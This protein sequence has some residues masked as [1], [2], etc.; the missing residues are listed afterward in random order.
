MDQVGK[1][2]Q[3]VS[4]KAYWSWVSIITGNGPVDMY[5]FYIGVAACGTQA[6]PLPVTAQ[7]MERDANKNGRK[8]SAVHPS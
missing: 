2:E 7:Q 1:S 5:C 8:N 4:C 6:V 3:E